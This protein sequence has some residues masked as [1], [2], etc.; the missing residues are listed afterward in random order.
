[1]EPRRS[2]NSN[3]IL[4]RIV[5][6]LSLVV[7]AFII[8]VVSGQPRIDLSSDW[9]SNVTSELV[10]LGLAGIWISYL[11]EQRTAQATRSDIDA[12]FAVLSSSLHAR[13]HNVYYD[14]NPHIS[15]R[16]TYAYRTNLTS[17]LERTREEVR[18]LSIAARE[19][20]HE[21]QGF[22]YHTM[23][24]LVQD[25]SVRILLLHPWSEQAVSRAIQEDRE[26]PTFKEYRETRLYQDVLRSCGT[27]AQWIGSIGPRVEARLYK[28]SPACFLVFV[29]DMVF[30][31]QYHFGTGGRASGKAP[32][33]QV[34]KGGKFYEQMEGHFEHVWKTAEPYRITADFIKALKDPDPNELQQF[35]EYIRFSRPDLFNAGTGSVSS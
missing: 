11:V 25:R 21:G 18:I 10:V 32:L 12:R 29:N 22:A 16:E 23:R 13:I 33:L 30:V 15:N 27:L 8:S 7:I 34:Y 5:M 24:S 17:E 28:V 19:F 1:M 14:E 4:I 26:H 3:E 31:E 2:R 35:E 20:L 9:F 6:S